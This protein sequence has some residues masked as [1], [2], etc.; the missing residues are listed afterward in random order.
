MARLGISE[1]TFA[2]AFLHEQTNRN[3]GNFKSYVA[4]P[5]LREEH[6]QPWDA[7]LPFR[8]TS[9]YYQFKLSDWL[10]SGNAK[11]RRLP[12]REYSRPYYRIN[13]YRKNNNKQHQMLWN[14]AQS[15]PET[16][17]VAP[18]FNS[19]EGFRKA[20]MNKQ[21]VDHSKL[22]PLVRCIKYSSPNDKDQHDITWQH[23][24]PS[25]FSQHSET[26]TGDGAIEG[27]D[28]GIIF[29]KSKPS[30]M[31]INEHFTDKILDETRKLVA[32]TENLNAKD[33]ALVEI[34]LAKLNT[35]NLAEG[36][37][38]AGQI[39]FA[40]SDVVLVIVGEGNRNQ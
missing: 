3:W 16:Y 29:E 13:L 26:H 8:G 15:N 11:Y 35:K 32:A 40:I 18:M 20:F 1:F 34:L 9:Y 28:L 14:F 33:H 7:E 21:V 31:E 22:I 23:L 38:T 5:S 2:F 37:Q 39:L 12:Q 36:I 24:S 6:T 17:Y 27:V 19:D 30:W 10:W 25:K 4:L